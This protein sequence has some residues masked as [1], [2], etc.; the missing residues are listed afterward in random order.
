MMISYTDRE[1]TVPHIRRKIGDLS[2]RDT[3]FVTINDSKR[4]PVIAQCVS[5]I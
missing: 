3:V 5:T 1:T 2:T 4:K